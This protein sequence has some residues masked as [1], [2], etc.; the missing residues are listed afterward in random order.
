MPTSV[1][2]LA[3][4]TAA[5]MAVGVG[6]ALARSVRVRAV[7]ALAVA[8]GAALLLAVAEYRAVGV[9]RGQ[10]Q[11][12][13]LVA[14]DLPDVHGKNLDSRISEVILAPTNEH[15]C[16][17]DLQPA[18][19]RHGRNVRTRSLIRSDNCRA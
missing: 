15:A 8:C 9:L 5:T 6:T 10:A 19:C 16:G 7:A 13:L 18:R 3:V 14:T 17:G 1:Q 2:I 11:F 4:I 12:V